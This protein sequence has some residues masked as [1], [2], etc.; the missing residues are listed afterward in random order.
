[1]RRESRAK[2]NFCQTTAN[3]FSGEKRTN[4]GRDEWNEAAVIKPAPAQ[5]TKDGSVKIAF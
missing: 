4:S 5:D 3:R 1:M 2:R